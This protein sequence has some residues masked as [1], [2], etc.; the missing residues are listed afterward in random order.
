MDIINVHGKNK[1]YVQD[2]RGCTTAIKA[3]NCIPA[4]KIAEKIDLVNTYYKIFT[5]KIPTRFCPSK[6]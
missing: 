5:R 1:N 4:K 6:I 2:R 3:D